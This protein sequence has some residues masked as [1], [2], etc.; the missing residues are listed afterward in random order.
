L[1]LKIAG[2]DVLERVSRGQQ[3]MLVAA[4]ILARQT[5]AR[6][7]PAPSVLLIDDFA[8][9]L[10]IANRERLVS[11]LEALDSQ[12]FLTVLRPGELPGIKELGPRMF[13]VE[14]G[15]VRTC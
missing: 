5:T 8:S 4:L 7:G 15:Q 12:L 13:H 10:D 9:E 6:R 14:Q 11:A 1:R 2:K 3:K